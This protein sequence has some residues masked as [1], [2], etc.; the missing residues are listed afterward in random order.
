MTKLVPPKQYDTIGEELCNEEYNS[1]R[2]RD[3]ADEELDYVSNYGDTAFIFS[4][5]SGAYEKRRGDFYPL[6]IQDVIELRAEL[7]KEETDEEETD[8]EETDEDTP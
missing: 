7:D 6:S 8:E 1:T 3:E 5:G 2:M 4:D